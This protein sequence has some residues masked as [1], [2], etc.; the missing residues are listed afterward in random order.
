[1]SKVTSRPLW[2]VLGIDRASASC[3]P[4]PQG[5][6]SH[7]YGHG[8]PVAPPPQLPGVPD[9]S[10]KVTLVSPGQPSLTICRFGLPNVRAAPN[11]STN[12]ASNDAG[13]TFGYWAAR[14]P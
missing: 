10:M 8:G 11:S 5:W 14:E 3:E 7:T 6:R 13:F 12:P 1:M 9:P 2:F 4:A